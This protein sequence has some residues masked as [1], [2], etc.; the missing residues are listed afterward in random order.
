VSAVRE[1]VWTPYLDDALHQ[2]R[3]EQGRR[4]GGGEGEVNERGFQRM[5]QR[6]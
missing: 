1:G 6:L 4:G 2:L 5:V 3:S